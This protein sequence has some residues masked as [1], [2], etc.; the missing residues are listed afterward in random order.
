[1]GIE[2]KDGLLPGEI[3]IALNKTFLIITCSE[4]STGST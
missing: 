4:A 2:K 1:M 3:G